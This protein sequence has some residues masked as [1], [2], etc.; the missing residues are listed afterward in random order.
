MIGQLKAA[1]AGA[2]AR[3]EDGSGRQNSQTDDPA[4]GE[5]VTAVDPFRPAPYVVQDPEED[6]VHMD[7]IFGILSNQRRRY[8]LTYLTMTEGTVTLSDLAERIAAWECEKDID[9]LN[10][11][12]RKRVYVSLYQGHLPK[13]ADAGAIAYDSDRGTVEPG[14]QFHHFTHYLRGDA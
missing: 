10:S 13:M 8:V 3:S 5:T 9:G 7:Q 1:L 2:D 4:A 6:R 14:E 12:E 11:Q